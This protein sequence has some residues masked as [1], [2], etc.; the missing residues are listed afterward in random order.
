VSALPSSDVFGSVPVAL[1][2]ELLRPVEGFGVR[3]KTRDGRFV[4]VS[5]PS[6][7]DDERRANTGANVFY[8][9]AAD[10]LQFDQL[11]VTAGPRK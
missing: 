1:G 10:C 2:A 9:V 8:F 4:L 7:D 5:H 11:A 3:Y 6:L